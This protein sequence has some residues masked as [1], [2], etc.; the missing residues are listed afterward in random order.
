MNFTDLEAELLK[1]THKERA[2]LA[3]KLWASLDTMSENELEEEWLDEAERRGAELDA[4][5]SLG[6]PAA[7]V[8]AELRATKR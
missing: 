5:P 4:D 6:Q 1:L 3:E 8:F 7:E 2:E